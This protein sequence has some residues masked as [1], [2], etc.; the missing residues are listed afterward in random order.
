MARSGRLAHTIKVQRLS[1]T[2]DADGS[3]S[4]T[5]GTVVVLRAARIGN[6]GQ[7][8][9]PPAAPA[10][11]PLVLR[12]RYCKDLRIADRIAFEGAFYEIAK[13]THSEHPRGVELHLIP[14]L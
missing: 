7:A 5:W 6:T 4:E 10:E 3:L 12:T 2:T 1:T 14:R 11:H 9:A 13:L 8:L